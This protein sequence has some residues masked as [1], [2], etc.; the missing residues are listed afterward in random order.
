MPDGQQ[1]LEL[2]VV[3]KFVDRIMALF[4][5]ASSEIH[6]WEFVYDLLEVGDSYQLH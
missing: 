4:F 5:M 3:I 6:A 2:W 1:R